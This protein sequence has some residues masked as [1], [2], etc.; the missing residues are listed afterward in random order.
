[1]RPSVLVLFSA[2]SALQAQPFRSLKTVPVPEPPQLGEYVRDKAA[3]VAL[4]KVFFWEMQVGS[5][6]R[7]AC[8]TCHF[9]AGADHRPQNQLADPNRAFT[10]NLP[11]SS[12]TFP[13]RQLADPNNRGSQALRDSSA[14]VGSMGL[15]R[16]LFNGLVLG[17]A[18]ESGIEALDTPEFQIGDRQVRRVTSRN[19]PTVINSVFNVRNFWDGRANATF[20]GFTPLG[21]SANVPGALVDRNGNLERVAVLFDNASL[22]SQAVG[23]AM[24]HLEMSYAGRTW[25]V[26]GKK[27]L[28]LRPLGHQRVATTDSVLGTWAAGEGPG[29]REDISY[30]GLI[31]EAF[32]P[33]YWQS[34]ELMDAAGAVLPGRR[35]APRDV[36]EFT[37]TEHNFSLFWGLAIAA[38]EAT[39]VSSDNPL[40]RFLD[41][42]PT[43]FTPLE[44][45]G[46]TV[47]TGAGRCNTCHGA[48][49]LTAA[50][51]TAA[52]GDLGTGFAGRSFRN[53]G[54]R[55]SNEDAG[56][57]NGSFKTSGLRDIDLTGPYFHNGGQA[58]LEQVVDFYS[59]AGDFGQNNLRTLNLS[60]TQRVALVAFLKALT[61]D[62]VR[63]ER[64]PFDHPQLCVPTGHADAGSSDPAYPHAAAESWAEVSAVGSS[65]NAVPLQT[66]EEMLKGL[67]ADGSREHTL[68]AACS[69]PD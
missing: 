20:N 68:T 59:R 65:G 66:F 43:A 52:S 69:I 55:P 42:D 49:E 19:S 22:S 33:A 12:L 11:L 26:L 9:H 44:R 50:S 37:Q 2:L 53:D 48:A 67:G 3:L 13:L 36:T 28:S 47:F 1:M 16:R 18:A 54:V 41:G 56:L 15:V 4:G 7:T 38:Y 57:A 30:Q 60:T 39:L 21:R 35:G 63:Y 27:L 61:D 58:T 29:L 40:D 10:A 23:P 6:G 46:L 31:Q 8:A 62:R 25:P 5:D 14:R 24:D 17:Q 51:F 45:E 34:N 32:V 64:A